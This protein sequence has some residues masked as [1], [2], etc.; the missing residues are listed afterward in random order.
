[1]T[2]MFG[3]VREPGT[4]TLFD[5]NGWFSV[6]PAHHTAS[7]TLHIFSRQSHVQPHAVLPAIQF[8]RTVQTSD[9]A[10]DT[11]GSPDLVD[12]YGF[13]RDLR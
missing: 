10:S 13:G 3:R 4:I 12:N 5:S 11:N 6:L 7:L 1:M 8:V 2:V 9:S